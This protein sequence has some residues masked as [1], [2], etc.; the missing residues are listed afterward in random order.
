[1][2][3]AGSTLVPTII[4]IPM[5]IFTPFLI[6]DIQPFILTFLQLVLFLVVYI[7]MSI[8]TFLSYCK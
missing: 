4:V 5:F 6:L 1:M 8:G 2:G 3:K 7:G